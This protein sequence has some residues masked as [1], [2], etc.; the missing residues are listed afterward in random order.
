MNGNSNVLDTEFVSTLYTSIVFKYPYSFLPPATYIS[1]PNTAN[2]ERSLAI[3]N[4]P[5]DENVW[6]NGLYF[7]NFLTKFTI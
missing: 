2:P 7:L 1:L 4:S 6:F 3:F 5:M